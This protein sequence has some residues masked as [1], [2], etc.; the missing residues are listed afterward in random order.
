MSKPVQEDLTLAARASRVPGDQSPNA[1]PF[2]GEDPESWDTVIILGVRLPGICE[3]KGKGFH[4]RIDRKKSPGKNG[5]TYTHLGIEAAKFDLI[6]QLWTEQHLLDFAKL[7]PLLK[8]RKK[9][10]KTVDRYKLSGPNTPGLSGLSS[11]GINKSGINDQSGFQG[12]TSSLAAK[13]KATVTE[14]GPKPIPIYHPALALYQIRACMVIDASLPEKGKGKDGDMYT[15]HL[16]CEEYLSGASKNGS[17]ST[18]KGTADITLLGKGA[19]SRQLQPS[20]PS[21]DNTGP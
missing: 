8:P 7:I 17:V 1:V 18:K 2:W 4:Q 21:D 3:V 12:L 20:T 5:C 6:I 9:T 16:S 15:V 10:T 14:G 19:L 11:S 13:Q